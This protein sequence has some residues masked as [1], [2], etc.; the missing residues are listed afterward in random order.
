MAMIFAACEKNSDNNSETNPVP[1]K[2]ES[3]Q[4]IKSYFIAPDG[5]TELQACSE[6]TYDQLGRIITCKNIYQKS[7]DMLSFERSVTFS[8][9]RMRINTLWEFTY[10]DG[11]LTCKISSAEPDFHIPPRFLECTLDNSGRVIKE[12]SRIE[13]DEY[14]TPIPGRRPIPNAIEGPIREQI[15]DYRLI[16]YNDEGYIAEL[17]YYRDEDVCSKKDRFNYLEGELVQA[18][19]VEVHSVHP[20]APMERYEYRYNFKPSE[21]YSDNTNIYLLSTICGLQDMNFYRLPITIN[22]KVFGGKV[23]KHLPEKVT[24]DD[25]TMEIKFTYQEDAVGRISTIML[26]YDQTFTMPDGTLDKRPTL[27]WKY[28]IIYKD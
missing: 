20:G 22:L 17:K 23:M 12:V 16:T 11:I 10:G 19:L 4:S 2:M 21:K 24:S 28:E 14:P 8:P 6:Y 18:E 13:Q 26:T 15:N 3:I 7:E 27:K 5:S 1:E 25:G 9:I